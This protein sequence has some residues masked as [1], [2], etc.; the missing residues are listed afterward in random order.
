MHLGLMNR[1]PLDLDTKKN[2]DAAMQDAQKYSK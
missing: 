1:Q 2:K